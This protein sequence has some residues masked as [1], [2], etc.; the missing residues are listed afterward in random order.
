MATKQDSQ[1]KQ[2]KET[3]IL[4]VVRENNLFCHTNEMEMQTFDFGINKKS[5]LL[6]TFLTTAILII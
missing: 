4:L 2:L 1:R 3:C 6:V 5:S